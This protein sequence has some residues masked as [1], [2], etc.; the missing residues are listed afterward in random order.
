MGT[1]EEAIQA[2]EL[3]D[4]R[5][6]KGAEAVGKAQEATRELR[7]T[8]S[9]ARGILRTLEAAEA[10]IAAMTD[11]AIKT[12]IETSVIE[13]LDVLGKMTEQQMKKSVTKVISEF[14]GLR[15]VLLGADDPSGKKT[16]PQMIV[17][18][19][20]SLGLQWD[21]F[22]TAIA[23][24]QAVMQGCSTTDCEKASVWAV[25]AMI[26]LPDGRRGE[27]HFHMCSAHKE[28]LKRDPGVTILK[29]FKLETTMCPYQHEIKY[30]KPFPE[31]P[32]E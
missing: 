2:A 31:A 29:S 12:R 11:E 20:R 26:E 1:I 15:D 24:A 21:V 17:D 23:A 27:A 32:E 14:D 13:Q 22:M 5:I 25:V 30:M 18:M 28:E 3:I 10:R 16:I 6:G 4:D 19:E 9:E 8:I 7:E